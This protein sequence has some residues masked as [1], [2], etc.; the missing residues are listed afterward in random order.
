MPLVERGAV[1][2]AAGQEIDAVTLEVLRNG[3]RQIC[4][5][6]TITL[7]K[8]AHSV[9]FNEGKDLSSAV[10]DSDARLVAQDMQ[11]CPVHIA[12][13][14]YSVKAGISQYGVEDMHP[15]DIFIINDSYSGGTHLPDVTVFAPVFWDEELVGFVGNRGHHTDVGGMAPGSMPGD[16]TEMYQEGLILPAVKIYEAGTKNRDVWNIILKNVRLPHNTR[17]DIAA[18]VAGVQT[19]M[20][21]FHSMLER[22]G[23]ES[24]LTG[25]SEI[26][27]YS[28]RHMR[29]EIQ[30]IPDGEYR[31]VDFMDTDGATGER[32][33]IVMTARKS[34]SDIEFDF[35]G[36]DLQVPGAVN[37]VFSVTVSSVYIGMLMVT[38]PN[39]HPS[40]GAFA[41]IKVTAPLGTCVNPN[42]PASTV[43]G[44]T[45][46][47]NRIIDMV[48]GALA[49]G[50]PD[51][52]AAGELGTCNVYTLGGQR[53][54]GGYG[55]SQADGEQWVAILNP[56]GG[57][58]GMS[59]KDGWTCIQDPLSN[60]R[61]QPA[62]ALENAF[63]FK[64]RVL[65]LR[66]GPEGAGRQRGGYGLRR[67]IEVT[68]A[69]VLST[70]ID[71]SAIPPFGL[72]GGW[73]GAPNL[74]Y[75]RRD[76][77][78]TWEP[79][80]P[81][82]SNIRLRAGDTVRIDTAIGGGFG[83]PLERDPGLVAEDVADDCL[84]REEAE[85]VYGVI[86]GDGFSVDAEG[87]AALRAR[88]EAR[89][90]DGRLTFGSGRGLAERTPI[91]VAAGE[92]S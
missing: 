72:F 41:P 10:F 20:R 29:S 47:C 56:K 65:S 26:I 69:C 39:I 32:V 86:L 3:F 28:E 19:G 42:P 4:E 31:F 37:C 55:G 12:G 2:N 59:Y 40:E 80:S 57:W 44:L 58:G 60:C 43:S 49:P 53:A 78:D 62:E 63:P 75:L 81:R 23:K 5:E 35:A 83:N 84:T 1:E 24:V 48:F 46:T 87:T 64:V 66:T 30:R 52:V 38:D 27:A 50:I 45:E 89:K 25:I 61:L 11:G 90:G 33:Q 21:R 54:E 16:A 36:S 13:M 67:D 71:R 68:G 18:Q 14:S 7:L 92:K 70:C 9:I 77:S 79:V 15:G 17:G 76:G 6:V 91:F 22:Y 8:T 34:G 82:M 51:R 73:D 88:L 85:H 74:I